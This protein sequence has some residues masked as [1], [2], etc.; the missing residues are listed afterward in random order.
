[1]Q[2][3]ACSARVASGLAWQQPGVPFRPVS[4]SST[5][6]RPCLGLV[7]GLWGVPV[8]T[9][10]AWL[11]RS[12]SRRRLRCHQGRC[13][14]LSWASMRASRSASL[15]ACAWRRQ[16][17]HRQ[18]LFHSH[19]L[20]PQSLLTASGSDRHIAGRLSNTARLRREW[21]Y[22]VWVCAAGHQHW[23]YA[24]PA[25]SPTQTRTLW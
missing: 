24:L 25:C 20:H 9:S 11:L 2:H 16:C 12:G 21:H 18:G 19:H 4:T 1:M 3:G 15:Q 17:E 14:A 10:L 23:L 8:C 22:K 7:T 5:L 13:G 6:V